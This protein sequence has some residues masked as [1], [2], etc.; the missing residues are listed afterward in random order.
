M[1]KKALIAMSGGVDSSVA[2]YLIKQAG[3]QCIGANMRLFANEDIGRE[4]VQTCCSL[5]GAE[6]ARGVAARL[7]MPF[8]VFNFADC[9]RAEVID[10][11]IAA[12][13][14]GETPNPCI[15]C[16]RRLKFAKLFQRAQELQYDYIVTGHYARVEYDESRG[17]WLLKRAADL[18]KDQS[19]VLYTLT[20]EQLAHTLFPL[21][22]LNKEKVRQIAA[23]Q[24]F[25]NAQKA[26]S[27]DICFVPGG[28]YAAFIEQYTGEPSPTGDFVDTSGKVIGRHRGLIRYTVGQRRGL[29]LAMPQ[30]VYVKEL[31]PAANTVT[32]ATDGELFA[33]EL[34]VKEINLIDR[35]YIDKPLRLQVKIRYN[36][37]AQWATVR[38]TAEDELFISF[39][40][41]QRA[42]ARGQAAVLYDGDIVVGGGRIA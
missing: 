18:H 39:D 15:E 2:A 34:T 31:N 40:E 29:G 30:P 10:R 27:Q 26:E 23:E 12:Y 36:Q 20:Q 9:F 5:D 14:A 1:A 28:D 4:D 8:Y 41:P 38:Q 11:F 22:G 3:Y 6:D 33:D 24:G 16:N 35:V 13:Q 19:Y 37:K 32:I 21:G 25:I 7:G 17:R 42:I